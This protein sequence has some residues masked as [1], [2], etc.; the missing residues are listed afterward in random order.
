PKTRRNFSS[1]TLGLSPDG[2]RKMCDEIVASR[3]RQLEIAENDK[4]PGEVYQL[5]Y[6]LFPV[7]RVTVKRGRQT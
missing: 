7:S 3:F 1:V 6:Q 4:D 2:Y 5:N